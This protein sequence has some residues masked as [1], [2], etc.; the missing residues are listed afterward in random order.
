MTLPRVR[1]S[2]LGSDP[3]SVLR[4]VRP[5]C[6]YTAFMESGANVLVFDIDRLAV[7]DDCV[8]TEGWLKVIYPGVAAQQIGDYAHA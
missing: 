5:G 3:D 8:M 6:P 4:L 1:L 2:E 7:D